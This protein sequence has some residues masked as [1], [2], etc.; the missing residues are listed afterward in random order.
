MKRGAY[1]LISEQYWESPIHCN[2]GDVDISTV[3]KSL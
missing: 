2:P 1:W 3:L